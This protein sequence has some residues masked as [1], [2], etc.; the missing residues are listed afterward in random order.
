M[1]KPQPVTPVKLLVAVL[2]SN[3]P[4][5]ERALALVRQQ[6]G[7]ID[8]CGADHPLDVTDYY[9]AEMGAN[10]Q[11]R[12]IALAELAPPE[13]IRGGKLLCNEL[14]DQLAGGVGRPVNLDI[15]FLDHNKLVLASVKY[16]GQK[17]HLGD[18]VY[19]DL[20]A[21]YAAGRYQPFE[22]TFPDFRDGRYDSELLEIRRRYLAQ[23]RAFRSAAK[24]SD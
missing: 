13:Y 9:R 5:L 14:E 18:G 23:L 11:R 4:L 1:A 3:Q 8:F 19:A 22:W 20:I 10:I 7:E 24:R 2:W 6:W 15:G 21:R 12:L 16:A 17:I